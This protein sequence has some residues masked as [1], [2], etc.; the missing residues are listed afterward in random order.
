MLNVFDVA[1]FFLSKSVSDTPHAITHLKL[2]K[3]VYYAQSWHKTILNKPLFNEEIEAW[4]HGPVIPSLYS[5]YKHWGYDVITPPQK[6]TLNQINIK[7]DSLPKTKAILEFVWGLYGTYTG[8]ELEE[9]THREA[10]W[11]IARGDVANHDHSNNI[12]TLEN[13]SNYYKQFLVGES[14]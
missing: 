14:N 7:L 10:P 13:M 9:L 6:E 12:I 11:R 8:K 5:M 2:Q 1:V 4:V 3:L